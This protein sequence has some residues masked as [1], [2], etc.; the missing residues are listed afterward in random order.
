MDTAAGAAPA[1]LRALPSWLLT[2]TSLRARRL[3]SDA[4]DTAGASRHYF[5]MLAALEEFGPANQA[6]LGRR[7]GID[8]SD[9]VPLVNELEGMKLIRRTADPTDRRRNVITISA[10]GTRRLEKLDRL[11]SEAQDELLEPLMARE[12]RQLVQLLTRVIDDAP[13]PPLPRSRSQMSL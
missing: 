10:A 13:P 5:S 3:V 11:L 9:M 4:L 12:R 2:Q 7:L 6:A 1:R 8:P